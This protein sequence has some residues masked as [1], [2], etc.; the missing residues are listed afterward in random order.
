[1]YK[2]GTERKYEPE[3]K[4]SLNRNKSSYHLPNIFVQEGFVYKKGTDRKYEPEIKVNLNRNK[5]S[6]HPPA[7]H[8][9]S[10]TRLSSFL[11]T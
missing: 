6:H 10:F 1:M 11:Y 3:I 7:W 4:V 2:K 9:R 5:S 8:P